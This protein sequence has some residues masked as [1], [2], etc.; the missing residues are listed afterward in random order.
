MVTIDIVT[1]NRIRQRIDEYY[2]DKSKADLP[3][4]ENFLEIL[5][6]IFPDIFAASA[7][8]FEVANEQ[9]LNAYNNSTGIT[10][11]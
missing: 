2:K 1:K 4:T 7:K 6:K 8:N 10:I 9:N 5:Q 11:N 3:V